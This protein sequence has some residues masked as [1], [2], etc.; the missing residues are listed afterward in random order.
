MSGL[1]ARGVVQYNKFWLFK[2]YEL[3]ICPVL[4]SNSND[5]HDHAPEST[6][7]DVISDMTLYLLCK[8]C[9]SL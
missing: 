2:L 4:C 7:M 6:D 9:I 1:C 3:A 5:V 8:F